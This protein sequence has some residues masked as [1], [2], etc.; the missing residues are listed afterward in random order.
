M[1]ELHTENLR[2]TDFMDVQTL[3]EIQDSFAAVGLDLHHA[4]CCSPRDDRC[5]WLGLLDGRDSGY[6]GRN[7]QEGCVGETDALLDLAVYIGILRV[8]VW[9][10][11]EEECVDPSERI[12]QR[13]WVFRIDLY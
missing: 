8:A 11:H 7:T 1:S 2:L 4:C 5:C 12:A 10:G 13:R 3:Q 9:R 6:R